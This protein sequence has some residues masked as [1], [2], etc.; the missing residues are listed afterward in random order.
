M[1]FVSWWLA[2]GMEKALEFVDGA[3]EPGMK[4]SKRAEKAWV[5][6]CI[7]P[8]RAMPYWK[9]HRVEAKTLSCS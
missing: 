3:V 1:A 7:P 8:A 2:A 9:G 5:R 6:N 4:Q